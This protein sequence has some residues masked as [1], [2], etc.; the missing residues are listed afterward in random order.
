[1]SQPPIADQIV[2]QLRTNLR[3][4]GIAVSEADIQGMVEKGFLARPQT[5]MEHVEEVQAIGTPDYLARSVAPIVAPTTG[6]ASAPKVPAV[7]T[8]PESLPFASIS[9]VAAQLRAGK[10]SPVELTNLMLERIERYD[11]QLNAFQQVLPDR[12]RA[13]A[14]QAE[15]E[16]AAGH[17]RGPLHGVPIVIK[18]LLDWAGTPTTAGSKILA[19]QVAKQDAYAVTQLEQAGAV[20]L[21]KTRMSEFAYSPGS[22]NGHYGS[23]HNPWDTTRDSGGSSSG[24]AVAVAAGLAFAALGSDTG[25][26]IRIPASLC[27]IVGLKPTF[28]R[29]SLHG[30]IPLAWSLDHLGPL[31]RTVADAALLLELLSGRDPRDPRTNASQPFVSPDFSRGVAGLRIGVLDLEGSGLQPAP[32]DSAVAAWQAGLAVL[33]QAGAVLVPVKLPNF[34]RLV[35]LNNSLLAMETLAFHLPWLRTRLDDYGE[36]MR[37]RVLAGFAYPSTAFVRA[38]QMRAELRAQLDTVFEQIDLLST[39]TQPDGAP[40]LGVPAS[41]LY[42]APFNSLGWPT[43]SVPVGFTPTGLPLGL[44]LSGKLWDDATV[45]RAAFALEAGLGQTFRPTL[46]G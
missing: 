44:Q 13:C 14:S 26:S 40:P 35:W 36:F 10:V 29:V 25:G 39:P 7:A 33:E 43:I 22:N 4:A 37:Q 16:L 42:T 18:D 6:I 15:R 34:G 2:D 5:F 27:G 32:E 31:T 20:I 8:E 11:P 19:D 38:Q 17:D 1:M 45:L 12:A 28:G 3:A 30:A 24:S 23:T 46:E 9:E 41:T 21:G